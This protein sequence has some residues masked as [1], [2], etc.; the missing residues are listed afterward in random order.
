VYDDPG[1]ENDARI[2]R[3]WSHHMLWGRSTM[4]CLHFRMKARCWN[5]SDQFEKQVCVEDYTTKCPWCGAENTID[6]PRERRV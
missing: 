5:C 3:E 6:L 1:D 4:S 2:D